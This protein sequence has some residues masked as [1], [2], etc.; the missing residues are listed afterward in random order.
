MQ[1][2]APGPGLAVVCNPYLVGPTSPYTSGY[3]VLA[4]NN[5]TSSGSLPVALHVIKIDKNEQY[6]GSIKMIES[7]N[8]FDEKITLRHTADFG[9]NPDDLRFEWWY[10]EEDGTDQ[11]PPGLAQS[12]V[13]SLFPDNSG[14]NGLGMNEICMAGTGKI[15]LVDN[16]FLFAIATKQP[17]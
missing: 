10:R 11:P 12:G 2:A 5:M 13:W 15:L 1:S 6:R 8:V 4:E 9:A 16:L 3:V 7:D 14:L 17:G